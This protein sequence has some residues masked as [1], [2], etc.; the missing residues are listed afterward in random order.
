MTIA[1]INKTIYRYNSAGKR[2]KWVTPGDYK[3]TS[4]IGNHGAMLRVDANTV[5][6]VS[7]T[8]IY[9]LDTWED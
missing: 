9:N 6:G 8:E 4:I 1:T 2:S 7:F 3:V 5:V